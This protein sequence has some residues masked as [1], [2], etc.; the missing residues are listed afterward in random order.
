MVYFVLED[1]GVVASCHDY[2]VLLLLCFV[3]FYGDFVMADDVALVLFVDG[4]TAFSGIEV[5]FP[6]RSG[7]DFWIYELIFGLSFDLPI[8]IVNRIGDDEHPKISSYLGSGEPDAFS[9][10]RMALPEFGILGGK[11]VVKHLI[12]ENLLFLGEGARD[13]FAAFP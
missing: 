4:E 12:D 13:F 2:D 3:G 5:G 6:D 1:D 9:G 8:F 10:F 7:G 11:E